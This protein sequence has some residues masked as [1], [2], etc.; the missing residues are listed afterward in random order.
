MFLFEDKTTL[1]ASY[2]LK[3]AD[4]RKIRKQAW[5]V[6]KYPAMSINFEEPG[7]RVFVVSEEFFRWAISAAALKDNS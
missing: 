4:W 5:Q 7:V 2:S 1:K 6:K 3:L